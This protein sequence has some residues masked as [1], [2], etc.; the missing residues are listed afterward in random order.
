MSTYSISRR[1]SGLAG[2]M[3][4]IFSHIRHY[5]ALYIM[6]IPGIT[7]YILFHYTP[8]FG[9]TMAF[10]DYKVFRGI[11]G[12][13]WVNL[14]HFET[15]F[16]SSSF[17]LILKNSLIISFAKLVF[18]FPMPIILALMINEIRHTAY[19][20]IVQTIIYLP[21]FLS[22]VVIAGIVVN[23]LSPSDGVVNMLLSLLGQK[24]IS[25]LTTSSYFRPIIIISDIWKT[26]GWGTIIFLAALANVDPELYEVAKIDGAGRLKRIIHITLPSIKSTIFV[27]LLLR[28]GNIMNNGFEQVFLL[29]NPMTMDVAD[30]FETYIYRVGLVEMKFD[31]STA[32]G[33][34]KSLISFVLLL[35]AN[36]SAKLAGEGGIF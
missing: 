5:P 11:A 27:M 20:R 22:W 25:F 18:C 26:S 19:K 36:T 28:I 6:L 1:K 8:M 34:F 33:L 31:Y 3:K 35:I 30:I 17:F 7:Y 4:S 24:K 32:V 14:K 13:P 29:S 12:S 15:L 2:M 21:Y 16:N 9:I 23:L 10:K